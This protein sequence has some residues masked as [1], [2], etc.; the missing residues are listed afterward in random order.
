M[1]VWV[2]IRARSAAFRL[3]GDVAVADLDDRCRERGRHAERAQLGLRASRQPGDRSPA[4]RSAPRAAARGR[5]S[6][7]PFGIRCADFAGELG[8]LPGHLDARR[9]GADDDERQKRI[10]LRRVVLDLGSFERREDPVAQRERAV[11]RLQL[12]R[13]QRPLVV[14]EVGVREPPATTR[15]S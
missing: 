12:G 9:P 11:E 7:R 1:T 15:M 2:S 6:C 10:A 8:D 5:G 3:D 4:T 13:V 14:A